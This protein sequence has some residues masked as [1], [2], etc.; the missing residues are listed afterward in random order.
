MNF[1][2]TLPSDP[3]ARRLLNEY[4]S[5]RE[6]GFTGATGY[7]IV[8][9]GDAQ[10]EPP[11]GVFLVIESDGDPIGC[12][13]IRHI[14][15]T[16]ID[17]HWFEVKHLWVEPEGRGSGLGRLLLAELEGRAIG[18]GATHTV[19]DTNASLEAAGGLYFSAGYLTIEPYND[20]PNATNWY[21]K[22]LPR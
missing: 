18:F 12:G 16:A 13:G 9:P 19:L 15:S 3:A 11:H 17:D 1:R 7:T 10:F 4:F 22:L 6:L 21:K 2:E 14:D 5:S 8:F 20:N